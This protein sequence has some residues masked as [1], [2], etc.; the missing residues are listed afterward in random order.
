M[1][2]ENQPIDVVVSFGLWWL[3]CLVAWLLEIQAGCKLW[4][5]AFLQ[6]K[7]R[8]KEASANKLSPAACP[9]LIGADAGCGPS[10]P[11]LV[12]TRSPTSKWIFEPAGGGVFRYYI[13]MHVSKLY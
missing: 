8:S 1:D 9:A 7:G 13:R 3:G 10:D 5:I 6:S 11:G 2:I 4:C 12:V